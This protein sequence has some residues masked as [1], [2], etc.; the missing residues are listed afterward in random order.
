MQSVPERRIPRTSDL[1]GPSDARG[2]L[3][4]ARQQRL[5]RIVPAS[6][7]AGMIDQILSLIDE[8][9]DHADDRLPFGPSDRF[10]AAEYVRRHA[11]EKVTDR[12]IDLEWAAQRGR[13]SSLRVDSRR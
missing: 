5:V 7:P 9:A 4:E 11:R 13:N 8:R 2:R 1:E 12:R 3:P 10:R 6:G